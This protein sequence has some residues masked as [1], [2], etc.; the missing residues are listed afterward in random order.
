MTVP[1]DFGEMDVR[2]RATIRACREDDLP[3]LEWMGL[4]SPDRV[5]IRD[6]FEAQRRGE[7]LMLLAVTAE[8]P[9]AQVWVDFWQDHHIRGATLWAVRTFPPLQGAGIGRRLMQ[10]AEHVLAR[11]GIEWAELEVEAANREVLEFYHRLGWQ[12]E[13]WPGDQRGHEERY[14]L[15]KSITGT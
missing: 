1:A 9:V 15:A 8:F 12:I 14:L 13:G 5:I 2:L 3:A 11:R 6:T 10:A 4:F 7:A